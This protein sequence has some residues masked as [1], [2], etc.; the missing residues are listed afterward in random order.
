[1]TIGD[2]AY[3]GTG[4]VLKQGVSIGAG[5][6]VGMGSVVIQDVPAGATVVGNPARIMRRSDGC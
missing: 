5:A 1:V 3:V 2:G 6:T 4:A